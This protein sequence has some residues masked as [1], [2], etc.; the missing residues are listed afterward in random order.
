M[1]PNLSDNYGTC[2]IFDKKIRSE[3]CIIKFRD[4]SNLN[5]EKFNQNL[6]IEIGRFNSTSTD[7]NENFKYLTE[8]LKNF[9]TSTSP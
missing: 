3:E 2:L 1:Q 4:F 7:T 5:I 8:F 6:E 9:L